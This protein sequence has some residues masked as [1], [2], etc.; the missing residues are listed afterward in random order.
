MTFWV[1][2]HVPGVTPSRFELQE[3]R[4]LVGTGPSANLRVSANTGL[5][6]GHFWI[7]AGDD[8]VSVSLQESIEQGLFHGGAEYRSITVPWNSD[9]FIGKVRAVFR[10]DTNQIS[11]AGKIVLLS[12]AF[13]AGLGGIGLYNFQNVNVPSAPQ[14]D[15]FELTD[16]ESTSCAKTTPD[17]A[18]QRALEGERAASAKQQRFPFDPRDGVQA[19][20]I[21]RN[22]EACYRAAAMDGD[23]SR[24]QSTRPL[25]CVLC[26]TSNTIEPPKPSMQSTNS[27]RFSPFTVKVLTVNG[28]HKRATRCFDVWPILRSELDSM[29]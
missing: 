9:V 6:Q 21:L 24:I 23:A 29:S 13:I 3:S 20:T 22:S 2:L 14:S 25:V 19:L 4:I 16:N 15:V 17:L 28:S 10:K 26:S 18:R 11:S 1:E 5:A 12:I 27:R 8:C 7:L